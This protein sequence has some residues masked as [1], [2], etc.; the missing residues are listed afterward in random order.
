M[1]IGRAKIGL[2]VTKNLNRSD[3]TD[4]QSGKNVS[5]SKPPAYKRTKA[6]MTISAVM[7]H[8]WYV[9]LLSFEIIPTSQ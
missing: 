1:G 9:D 3:Q 7:L 8:I 4:N 6:R 2:I 5:D